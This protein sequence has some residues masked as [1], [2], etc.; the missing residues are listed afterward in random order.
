MISHPFLRAGLVYASLVATLASAPQHASAS[1]PVERLL[2]VLRS[3]SDPNVVVLRYGVASEGLLFSRDGGRSFA[4]MCTAGIEPALERISAGSSS[5][6][7][8]AVFDA[9]GR[10]LVNTFDA[11]Y[12]D[13]GTGCAW[14]K[15]PGIEG[16]WLT[17]IKVDPK[18]QDVLAVANV[19]SGEDDDLVARSE[20]LRRGPDGTWTVAGTLKPPAART[21]TYGGDLQAVATPTGSRLYATIVSSTGPIEAPQKTSV[22]TSDDGGKTWREL[23]V[24]AA[25]QDLSLLAVDPLDANRL[26]ASIPSDDAPDRLLYSDNGG[27]SFR[28]YGTVQQTSGVTFAPDGRMFVGDAGDSASF[29]AQGGVYMA[30]RLGQPLTKLKPGD[31]EAPDVDC[32]DFNARS[33]KLNVCKLHRYGELDLSTGVFTEVTQIEKVAK[34]LECPN[35]DIKAVCEKQLNAGPAWCCTGHY[36]FT[37]FCGDYDVRTANGRR[38]SCGISGREADIAAGRGPLSADAGVGAPPGA[39]SEVSGG[40]LMSTFGDY[41]PSAP[42]ASTPASVREG[43]SLGAASGR[44]DALGYA[45]LGLVGLTL[46]RASRRRRRGGR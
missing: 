24:T 25:Q 1:G 9:K 42:T 19:S 2:Q 31:T 38:V 41:T 40:P 5:Y 39:P 33:Q 6:T 16:K 7:P 20:L 12:A 11:V 10:L 14:N 34:L 29:D 37:P 44:P 13:D 43:C 22:V 30:A 21:R 32:I 18:T 3:P 27:K 35:K 17:S 26:L 45:L 8:P 23:P 46:G 36:P 15:E 4:A 28:D